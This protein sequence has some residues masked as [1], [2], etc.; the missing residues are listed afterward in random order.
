MEYQIHRFLCRAPCVADG[1]GLSALALLHRDM[2]VSNVE[3][4]PIIRAVLV[5]A[6]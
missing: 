3:I 2:K 5:Q 6:Y 4:P 1:T